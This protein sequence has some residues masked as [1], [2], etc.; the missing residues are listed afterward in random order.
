[1]GR[2]YY[3]SPESPKVNFPLIFPEANYPPV[4]DTEG[5]WERVKLGEKRIKKSKVLICGTARDVANTFDRTRHYIT[6]IGQ[7]FADYHVFIYESDSIDN[8][9]KLLKNWGRANP[10]ISSQSETLGLPRLSDLSDE[11]KRIMATIRNKYVSYAHT[12]EGDFQYVCVVD[13]DMRGSISLDGIKHSFGHSESWDA[14]YSNGL[15]GEQKYQYDM[16]VLTYS[17]FTEQDTLVEQ[18]LGAPY[19]NFKPGCVR[20]CYQRGEPLVRVSSAFGGMGFYTR[21]AFLAGRY[22]DDPLDHIGFNKTIHE[23]GFTRKFINPSQILIR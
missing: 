21:E 22:L 9:A 10:K 3:R 11:R 19:A 14:V 2:K 20:P 23:A 5:Y 12:Y 15:D 17:G 7:L 1:M 4:C 8:T 13:M 16:A 6:S 18:K